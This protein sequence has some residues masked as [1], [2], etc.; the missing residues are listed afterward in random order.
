M[1]INTDASSSLASSSLGFSYSVLASVLHDP[2][3]VEGLFSA[4]EPFL[5]SLGGH[6]AE[7][8]PSIGSEDSASGGGAEQGFRVFFILT[9]GTEGKAMEMYSL[10]DAQG[11]ILP[12]VL[13]AHP[14]H[15]SLPAALEIAAKIK[16]QK[17]AAF[18]VFARSPEDETAKEALGE[19]LAAFRAKE[20]LGRTRIGAVGEASDWLVASSH[21][22]EVCRRTWG[23]EL[24]KIP[25]EELREG[26]SGPRD[27]GPREVEGELYA[28]ASYCVEPT[29]EDLISSEA[30]YRR[31]KVLAESR[32]LDALTLRCFD[33]VTGLGATGCYALSRLA[34]EGLDSGCEGDI[35]SII[36]LCWLKALSGRPAWMANPSDVEMGEKC[37]ILLAHCTVPRTMLD[38][39]GVRSH[40]ESGL[41]VAIAGKFS[42]GPVTL[43]RIG[44]ESLDET[45]IAEGELVESPSMEGL[46]RTQAWVE[47]SR[48]D[49]QRL[50]DNPLGNHLVMALGRQGAK[51]RSFLKVAGISQTKKS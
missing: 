13:V 27:G 51:A 17:G 20:I 41:G 26:L 49:G 37:R 46:C 11:R 39:Y 7:G 30:I 44:G 40:F 36:G 22:A 50:L 19:Y 10:P 38:S 23:V 28:K 29:A 2:Q 8:R 35:P 21:G 12:A 1:K 14:R 42:P 32:R 18:L 15:N 34:D 43:A 5:A 3:S 48:E 6:R 16:R 24:V 33:L 4:Y 31:L 45:W 25:M 47:I 9:G